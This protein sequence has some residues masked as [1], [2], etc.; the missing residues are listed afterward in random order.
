MTDIPYGKLRGL[1]AHEII[2]ALEKD[3][4]VFDRQRGSHK[5]YYHLDGR[6]A[7]VAFHHR[8]QTFPTGTLKSIIN[9]T[10]WTVDDLKRLK[11]LAE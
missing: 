5:I 1:T 6:R 2:Q 10:K 8:S 3:G 4:F 7:V 9:D 11:L